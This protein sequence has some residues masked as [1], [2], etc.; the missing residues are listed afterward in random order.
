MDAFDWDYK[1]LKGVHPFICTHHIYIKEGCNPMHQSQIRMKPNLEDIVK[2]ELQKLLYVGF[3]YTISYSDWVLPL[4]LVLKKNA[5][6]RIYVD[7]TEHNKATKKDRF[8]FPF[9]DQVLD[10]LTRN[11]IILLPGWI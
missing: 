7:Y 1:K 9:I 10:G 8:P 4:V 3:I 6:W 2:E 5:K 11:K